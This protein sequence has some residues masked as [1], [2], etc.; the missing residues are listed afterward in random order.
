MDDPRFQQF[1]VDPQQTPQR[2]Y[3]AIRAVI[4]EGQ[5][6]PAA[7]ARFGFAYGTLRNLVARFRACIR[8]GRKPPF[9]LQFHADGPPTNRRNRAPIDL[10]SPIAG[11]LLS[12]AIARSARASLGSSCFC[13]YSPSSAWIAWFATQAIPARA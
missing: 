3:E 4:L 12:T 10:P 11:C 9:S 8:Q 2:H 1:F 13:P 7:A 5:S 6:L